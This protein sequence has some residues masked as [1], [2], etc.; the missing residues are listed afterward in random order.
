MKPILFIDFDGTIAHDKYWRSLPDKE[1]QE[2]QKLL[3]QDNREVVNDW[4]RGKYSAE[5]INRFIANKTQIEYKKLWDIFVKDCESVGV[6]K[7]TL[8][9]IDSL[10]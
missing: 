9:K 6:S 3:F 8:K 7:S 5:E 4:M 1:F 2:V 10:A